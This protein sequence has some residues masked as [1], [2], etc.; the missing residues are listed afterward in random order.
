MPI[1]RG[2]VL[3]MAWLLVTAGLAFATL[4]AQAMDVLP[5]DLL[6]NQAHTSADRGESIAPDQ[7][8]PIVPSGKATNK[9]AR[10]SRSG[11]SFTPVGKKEIDAANAKKN[12]G[13]NRCENCEVEVV[14]GQKS[15]SGVSPPLNQRERD[16]IIPK[17]KGGEGTPSNGQV[18]C[19]ECNLE[20][21]N[22]AP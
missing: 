19:R 10:G 15:E 20:K 21:S 1:H 22:K 4:S 5:P 12:D 8:A 3:N 18:L 13:V 11:K 6:A 14:P 2:H 17:S 16:H 9:G 7:R